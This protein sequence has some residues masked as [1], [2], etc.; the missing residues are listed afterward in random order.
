M[1]ACHRTRSACW[2]RGPSVAIAVAVLTRGLLL[3]LDFRIVDATDGYVVVANINSNNQA[4]VGGADVL[5]QG[6]AAE[7]HGG[8]VTAA[9]PAAGGLAI[10]FD[11]PAAP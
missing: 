7:A 8:Q 1:P 11:L 5:P 3:A 10:S 4:V 2:R 9:L 6:V